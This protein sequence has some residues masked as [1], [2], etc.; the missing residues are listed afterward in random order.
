MGEVGQLVAV[1]T[2]LPGADVHAVP[3]AQLAQPRRLLLGFAVGVQYDAHPQG[4]WTHTHKHC[5]HTHTHTHIRSS[6]LTLAVSHT[7]QVYSKVSKI[8]NTVIMPD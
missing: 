2:V 6:Q 8:L 4:T 3:S 7:M 5:K 1:V